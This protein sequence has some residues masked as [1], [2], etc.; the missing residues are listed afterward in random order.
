MIPVFLPYPISHQ[1]KEN[2]PSLP[3]IVSSG[4][5][6][7][8]IIQLPRLHQ[9]KQGEEENQSPNLCKAALRGTHQQLSTMPQTSFS[10]LQRPQHCRAEGEQWIPGEIR[11]CWT[12]K[13]SRV[14]P[15]THPHKQHSLGVAPRETY[16]EYASPGTHGCVQIDRSF[17]VHDS[18]QDLCWASATS[19]SRLRKTEAGCN[20]PRGL[21]RGKAEHMDSSSYQGGLPIHQKW[22]AAHLAAQSHLFITCISWHLRLK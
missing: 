7:V 22:R 11:E 18:L 21:S 4:K 15:C 10:S 8:G 12:G 5:V 6:L 19:A 2:S 9:P 3:C 20:P 14:E 13:P 17:S 1:S 16:C